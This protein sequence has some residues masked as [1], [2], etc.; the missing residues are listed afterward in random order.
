MPTAEQ[1]RTDKGLKQEMDDLQRLVKKYQLNLILSFALYFD[2]G[3][4]ADKGVDLLTSALQKWPEEPELYEE[5]VFLAARSGKIAVAEKNLQ[6]AQILLP[7][8][9]FVHSSLGKL[10]FLKG[11]F[12]SAREKLG[13][14]LQLNP[15]DGVNL[16]FSAINNLAILCQEERMNLSELPEV[17]QIEKDLQKSKEL[18]PDIATDDF[19]EGKELLAQSNY[20]E[21]FKYLEKSLKCYLNK[22]LEFTRFHQLFFSFYME[23]ENFDPE[24]LKKYIQD[25]EKKS[26]L[27]ISFEKELN[28]LGCCYILF[29]INLVKSSEEQLQKAL[30]LDPEFKGALKTLDS[31]EKMKTEM[32]LLVDSLRF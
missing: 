16:L 13:K 29:F 23:P 6:E 20:A 12:V 18:N 3:G 19:L 9:P 28:R 27:S 31:L 11:E 32:L 25:L 10:Y 14:S 26:S 5:L 2:S 30:I 7:D 4:K 1:T 24:E 17:P 22:K 21:A 8:A 15:E